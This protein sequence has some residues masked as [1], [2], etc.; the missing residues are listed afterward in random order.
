MLNFVLQ[1]VKLRFKG[2]AFIAK[3]SLKIMKMSALEK[4]V[5]CQHRCFRFPGVVC[6]GVVDQAGR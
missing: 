3:I 1:L 5:N 2:V 6:G 4:S